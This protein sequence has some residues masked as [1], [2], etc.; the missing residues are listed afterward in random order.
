MTIL[1]RSRDSLLAELTE[2]HLTLDEAGVPRQVDGVDLALAARV[3]MLRRA[4]MAAA[5]EEVWSLI[6]TI[7]PRVVK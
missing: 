5:R 4:A 1:P 7:R 3:G 2:A 6:E